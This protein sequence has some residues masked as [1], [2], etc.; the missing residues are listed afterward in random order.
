VNQAISPATAKLHWLDM[1]AGD[2]S[3]QPHQASL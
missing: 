3:R 1:V 2:A